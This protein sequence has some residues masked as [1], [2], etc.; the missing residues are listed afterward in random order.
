MSQ[1]KGRESADLLWKLVKKFSKVLDLILRPSDYESDTL[2]AELTLQSV[3]TQNFS[4]VS[5]HSY[6]I[7]SPIRSEIQPPD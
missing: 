4:P 1:M 7:Y 3:G 2:L 5:I 6:E